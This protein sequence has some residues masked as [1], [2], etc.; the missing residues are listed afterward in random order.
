MPEAFDLHLHSYYSY[1]ARL[2]PEELFAAA[3]QAGLS[4][5]AITDHHNMDGFAE[6]GRAAEAHPSVCWLPAMEVSVATEWGDLDV[7]ALG[8]PVEVPGSLVGTVDRYRRWMRRHNASLL[9]GMEA[10]GI[11]FGQTDAAEMLRTWRPGPGPQVQGEVRLPNRGLRPW[12]IDRGLLDGPDGFGE[13]MQRVLRA[14]GGRPGL[15]AAGE[16]LPQFAEAGAALLLAHPKGLLADLGEAEFGRLIEAV[17]V[18]GVEAGHATHSPEQAQAY[19]EFAT[20]RGLLVSGGS[21]TH[22]PEDLDQLG[23]HRCAP[24]WI[25]PMLDRLGLRGL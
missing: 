20:A 7:V 9:T 21:D 16:V 1:D 13:L 11:P 22:V 24:D 14:G 10:L 15:P 3:E 18:H 6:F 19:R 2:S 23:R 8:V 25:E 12:L 17:G 4:L 5:V